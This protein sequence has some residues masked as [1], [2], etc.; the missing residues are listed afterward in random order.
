M[1]RGFGGGAL[2]G[3]IESVAEKDAVFEVGEL[4][5]TQQRRGLNGR[6]QYEP[7]AHTVNAA[8]AQQIRWD[9]VAGLGAVHA[10][11]GLAFFPWFF[12]WTGVIL[13]L[14]GIYVFGTLGINIGYHRLLTHRSF[15]CPRWFERVLAALGACCVQD[16]PP[17]WIAIHRRHHQFADQDDD[18]HSVVGHFIWGYVGWLLFRQEALR[19]NPLLERYAKDLMRD[20][21]YA[22]L[23]R[24]DNWIKVAV[25]SWLVFFTLGAAAALLQGEDLQDGVQFGLSLM[26][27][28][29]LVRTVVFWHVTWFSSSIDHLWGYRNYDTPDNSRNNVLISILSNGEGWHNNHHADPRSANH[30]HKPGE[31]DLSW[32]TIKLLTMLGLAREVVLPSTRLEELFGPG[33]SRAA[34]SS[35]FCAR[36]S[37]SRNEPNWVIGR[38]AAH[39]LRRE[40]ISASLSERHGR[41]GAVDLGLR[42][43]GDGPGR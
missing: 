14:L 33:G 28:G 27:W 32:L 15:A 5:L 26:I 22:W 10:L 6:S 13:A 38:K 24:R 25:A 37:A 18:P 8:P 35:T 41:N 9:R 4:A 42:P 39:R 1:R 36:A 2:S 31:F 17:V 11:A 16:S 23:E 21:F 30:G 19:A 34:G 20:P 29:A 7:E 43:E 3:H 12:S 40:A